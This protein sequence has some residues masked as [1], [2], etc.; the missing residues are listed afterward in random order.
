MTCGGVP[1]V[2]SRAPATIA[3][4]NMGSDHMLK[5]WPTDAAALWVSARRRFPQKENNRGGAAPGLV[6]AS[7]LHYSYPLSLWANGRGRTRVRQLER[8]WCGA[9]KCRQLEAGCTVVS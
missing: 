4:P 3:K 9:P 7:G 8:W 2:A 5:R 1:R 6:C